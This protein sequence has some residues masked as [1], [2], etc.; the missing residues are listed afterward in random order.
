[1]TKLKVLIVEDDA[2]LLSIYSTIL[3]HGG[4]EPILAPNARV[5]I[6]MVKQHEPQLIIEDLSLPDLTGVQL[7]HCLRQ[8]PEGKNIP[9]IILSGSQAR[10][11]S[12]R[13]SHEHFVAFLLKPVDVDTLLNT[14]KSILV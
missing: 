5:A 2:S 11:E 3:K 4:Y 10:I 14:V 9:V 7:V 12:A 6:D 8:I 13:Q 1:M